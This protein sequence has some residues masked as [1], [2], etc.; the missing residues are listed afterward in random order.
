MAELIRN[1]KGKGMAI[2]G[3]N[4]YG[5]GAVSTFDKNSYRQ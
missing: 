5:N 1:G 3:I 4:E 2:I